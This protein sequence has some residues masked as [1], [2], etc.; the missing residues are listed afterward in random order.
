MTAR[1]NSWATYTV[2]M[3]IRIVREMMMMMGT[4]TTNTRETGSVTTM[5]NT[6]MMVRTVVQRTLSL[7]SQPA[8]SVYSDLEPTLIIILMDFNQR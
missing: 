6:A 3:S 7:S 1:S 5:K 4:L 8:S 2:S